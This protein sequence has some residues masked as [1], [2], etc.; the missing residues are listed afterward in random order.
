M[1]S[2]VTYLGDLRTEARHIKSGNII[3]TDAP[4]DNKG[5]GEAFSPTDLTA[6]SLASCILTIMGIAA[7][8]HK[9]DIKGTTAEVHKFMNSQPRYI[10]EIRIHLQ[11]PPK[12]YSDKEKK[13]LERAA[14]HCPV[15]LSLGDKTQ[16]T[17]E[18]SWSKD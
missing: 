8:E 15:A 2:T 11:M 14:H 13:I 18:I 12:L 7:R 4:T 10:S 16:E 3:M 1:I 17:I 5:K 9:I 6:T